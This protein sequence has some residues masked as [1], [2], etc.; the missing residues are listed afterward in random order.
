MNFQFDQKWSKPKHI[1]C[2]AMQKLDGGIGRKCQK[3]NLALTKKSFPVSGKVGGGVT[4]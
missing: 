2:E 3:E 1:F 4:T